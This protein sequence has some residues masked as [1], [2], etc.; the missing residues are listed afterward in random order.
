MPPSDIGLGLYLHFPWCVRKC[1]YCDFNSHPLRGE[2]QESDYLAALQSDLHAALNGS[3]DR[4]AAVP[5]GAIDSVFC[6]GGTPSLFSPSAFATL[7][8]DL[9]PWLSATA[10]ITLEANPGTVEHHDFAAYRAAGINR[11]SLG[12][13]S[14]DASA[15]QTLGRI[16]G[17]GEI[18][19]AV[20]RARAGGFDN[21][22]LDIMYGLPEQTAAAAMD[23][24]HQAIDL[25]P[26]HISWYEL[27]IEP[28]T[29][30]AR[31]PPRLAVDREKALMERDGLALL[32][33]AGYQ[34]YEVSAFARPGFECRHNR[35]YWSFGDYLGA[36]AGAHGKRSYRE[37]AGMRIERTR[38]AAQPRLYMAD[39]TATQRLRVDAHE[40]PF[41]FMMNALRLIDGVPTERFETA[42]GL[43]C[44]RLQPMWRGLQD[45]GLVRSTRLA[46]TP[47]GLRHLDT[48]LQR[49]LT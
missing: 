23:D 33:A 7:L 44:N 5:H 25:Q 42:T 20:R 11:V 1:P 3:E 6:G 47:L 15:L 9:A 49:F 4:A 34:R 29:E 10:E 21:I 37:G 41:E 30:F 16:H 14:F 8:D 46:T 43:S 40:L 35:N 22:N 2:L 38:K 26:Q 32:E 48:V 27:T 31:R 28:K 39:P 18:L 24:L 36:G 13:Q 45:Q 19:R 12:A 17:P